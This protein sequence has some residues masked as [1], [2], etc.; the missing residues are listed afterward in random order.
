MMDKVVEW[1]QSTNLPQQIDQA[2]FGG[3]FSNPW[4]LVPFIGLL[5]YLLYK[6]N[7]KEIVLIAIGMIIWYAANTE[8]M[9][10]MIV[11]GELQL[12]KVL[13]VTFGGAVL[14]GLI[15]YM[16]FGRSD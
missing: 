13:P 3:L 6:Q 15:I 7:F 11:D 10:T 4:F 9:Q 16:Y 5:A 14:M 12:D 2:D 8:Y 1:F